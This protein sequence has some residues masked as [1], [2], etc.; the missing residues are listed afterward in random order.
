MILDDLYNKIL[1]DPIKKGANKI[2]IISGYAS[3][4]FSKRHLLD[5]LKLNSNIKL[6][7]IIG[8]SKKIKDHPAY[9]NII[10]NYPDNFSA[11]YYSKKPEVHSKVY[12]FFKDKIPF[13]GFS[14]SANYT[15]YGFFS[16]K[17]GNQMNSDDS[18]Q[19]FT[20]YNNLLEG[21]V[22]IK[23]YVYNDIEK[24]IYN[25]DEVLFNPGDIEWI[26][27]NKTV[28]ISLLDIRGNLPKKSGLNWGQRPE[29]N[30]D[31]NQ[32]YLSIRK[33]A[34][35]EGFLPNRGFTFSLLTDD[36]NTMDCTVQQDGRKAISTTNNNSELGLYFRK[37][38]GI[39]SGKMI[40]KKDL[41]KYGRTDFILKKLNDETFFLDFK[42]P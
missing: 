13:L 4:T 31:P 23:D 2:F 41:V 27:E 9:I 28:R 20:Y 38:L 8:M 7:L 37:R 22:N 16:E 1:L 15:Q 19:I 36:D 34:R 30:R 33:D 25:F 40:E 24:V 21:S 29:Y 32:A 5:A 12:S 11:F 42:K 17:Q 18:E 14:G 3:A 10:K 6:N 35:K 26:D 39:L